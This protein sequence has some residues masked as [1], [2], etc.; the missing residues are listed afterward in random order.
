MLQFFNIISS[1]YLH[2]EVRLNP[3][4]GHRCSLLHLPLLRDENLNDLIFLLKFIL[5]QHL[6][7]FEFVQQDLLLLQLLGVIVLRR[8]VALATVIARIDS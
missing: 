3:D 6:L 4:S 7:L 1:L 8:K 2:S 5:N